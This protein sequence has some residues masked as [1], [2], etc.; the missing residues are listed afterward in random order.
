MLSVVLPYWLDR[1]PLEAVE[2]A[3]HADE[4]GFPELWIGEMATFDAFALAGALARETKQIQLTV[5]P[6]PVGGRSAVALA[7][8]IGS[9]AEL[10]GRP[11]GVALGA[12]NPMIV[13]GWHERDWR[14]PPA[15]M[16][17]M[18]ETLRQLFS[19]ARVQRHDSILRVDNFKLRTSPGRVPITVAA[20]APRM[21]D[22]AARLG[23]RVVIN[24]M[25]VE[26]IA[27][28]RQ[29]LDSSTAATRPLLACW[30]PVAID[31]SPSGLRQLAEQVAIYLAAPGYAEMFEEAGFTDLVAA[32]RGGARRLELAARISVDLLQSV[33]AV[34]SPREV[35]RLLAARH[36][37]GADEI[38]LVPA[39]ADDPG[40]KRLLQSLADSP[41]VGER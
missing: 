29:R 18:I 23:D 15:R 31:P 28:I 35:E 12:S 3:R 21:L 33:A 38:C 14:Q 39:T 25:T 26:Q 5:G 24:L 22:V 4:L 9:I 37:A 41:R 36:A 32:A 2:I 19:G 17:A 13:S 40:A 10:A 27:K 34:G 1:A 11:V 30:T 6:L 8:G 7:L 20:F 16:S